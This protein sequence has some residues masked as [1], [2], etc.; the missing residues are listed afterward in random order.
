[1]I[2][3]LT[4]KIAAAEG[5]VLV[6]D[7]SG[8]GY[9]VAVPVTTLARVPQG[10]AKVTLHIYTHVREDEIALYGFSQVDEKKAFQLLIG[11]TG[12][13][14]KVALSIL[15]AMEVGSLAEAVAAD[16]TRTLSRIPGIGPKTAQRMVL[17]LKEKM[18]LL[19]YERKA[20]Q[21]SAPGA[22]ALS[23]VQEDVT[24][25]LVNLGYNK[26]DARRAAEHTVR[27]AADKTDMASLLRLALQ[28][29][30][31]GKS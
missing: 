3:L 15:S 18:A 5:N 28:R 31:S 22:T 24:D 17:E 20:V 6:V 23:Q 12:I 4:G 8:V 13:G 2:A 7:V 30:T 21:P 1:M 14:P 25:G 19:A 10:D 11:V 16:D 26:T 9:Q 27:D 29:L